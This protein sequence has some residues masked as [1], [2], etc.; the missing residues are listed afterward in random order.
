MQRDLP[1]ALQMTA[2]YL[3]IKGTHGVQE[4]LPNTLSAG[5]SESVPQLP[6]RIRLRTSEWQFDTR[7][8]ARSNCGAGCAPGLPHR[9]ST[10][11]PS[12]STTM[13]RSAARAISRRASQTEFAAGIAAPPPRSAQI[14]QNWL[15]LQAE[16]S[17]STFD[18]R[19]LLNLQ[20]QYT[21]GQGLEGGT[22]LGGWRGRVLK[23]WT[24]L[25]QIERRQRP[26]GNSGL[27]SRP[28]PAPAAPVP[29]RPE[30]NRQPRYTAAPNG[31]HI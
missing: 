26:A 31:T 27:S 14:A 18:Q 6:L 28:C 22:L 25:A 15:D 30:S 24:L 19:Q 12:P 9:C 20:A 21:T 8:P 1:W 23:E 2:T 10:P 13:L 16:R 29:L 7:N 3:G 17:L 11:T 5:R 4:F